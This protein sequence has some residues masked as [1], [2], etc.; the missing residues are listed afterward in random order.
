MGDIRLCADCDEGTLIDEELDII[1]V[2]EFIR[3][4]EFEFAGHV[5]L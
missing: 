2:G 5:E 3:T 1:L 4:A